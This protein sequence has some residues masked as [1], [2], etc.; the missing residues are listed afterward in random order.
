MLRN[1]KQNSLLLLLDLL[2][3]SHRSL[4]NRLTPAHW[5]TRLDC[6]FRNKNGS[7]VLKNIRK[8]TSSSTDETS[9]RCFFPF[10]SQR[11]IFFYD[12]AA[13]SSLTGRTVFWSPV[14]TE[15]HLNSPD[16]GEQRS[17]SPRVSLSFLLLIGP[18][19]QRETSRQWNT[20]SF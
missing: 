10:R 7:D 2:S 3:S 1:Y 8:E 13:G 15:P 16:R 14:P 18:L 19:D 5:R 12:S 20:V 6:R 4:S 9:T 17:S 11:S